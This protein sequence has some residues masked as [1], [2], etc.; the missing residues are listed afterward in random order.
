MKTRF[1]WGLPWHCEMTGEVFTAEQVR[2]ALDQ[3][4]LHFPSEQYALLGYC[5]LSYR[6]R[7][8]I[9]DSQYLDPSTVKRSW[10]RL[11][12]YLK[13]QLSYSEQIA[14]VTNV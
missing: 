14:E 13:I 10:D 7:T 8:E 5:W 3:V 11:M 12:H 1:A 9:A 2:Q 6:T 4:K